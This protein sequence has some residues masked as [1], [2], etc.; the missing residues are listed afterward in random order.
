MGQTV[1]FRFN[2]L[3]IRRNWH[4]VENVFANFMRRV[5]S[6]GPRLL[7]QIAYR[8]WSVWCGGG[9][10]IV[11]GVF[12]ISLRVHIPRARMRVSMVITYEVRA[13]VEEAKFAKDFQVKFHLWKLN[14][15]KCFEIEYT[16]GIVA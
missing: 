8:S 12:W 10:W 15:Q 3:V 13:W 6:A 2:S 11:E 7:G 14:F 4:G 5:P 16:L 9:V 1:A